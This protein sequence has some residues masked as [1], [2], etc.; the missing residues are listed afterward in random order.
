MPSMVNSLFS[1]KDFSTMESMESM[2]KEM[3][4]QPYKE[5]SSKVIGCA[6]EV[7]SNLG[8]VQSGRGISLILM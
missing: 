5:L 2:E 6:I 1:L 3:I 8:S 4:K 7:H